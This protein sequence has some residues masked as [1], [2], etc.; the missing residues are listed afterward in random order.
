MDPK[1]Y[2]DRISGLFRD[3]WAKLNISNDDFIRTTEPRH[4]RTVQHILQ[5]VFDKGDIYFSNYKGLYCVGCERFYTEREL[6]DGKC[7]DH[8]KKPVEREEA[9][10]FSR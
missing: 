4:V 1:S 2:A 9:N 5:K 8:D 7:P 3:T 6:V 10:Y